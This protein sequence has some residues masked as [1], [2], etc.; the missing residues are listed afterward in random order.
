MSGIINY[1]LSELKCYQLVNS[2][3]FIIIGLF[4]FVRS[5]IFFTRRIL[6]IEFK[7]RRA[8]K[9]LYFLFKFILRTSFL[10]F[11]D[12]CFVMLVADLTNVKTIF[13][14]SI[15]ATLSYTIAKIIFEGNR[16]INLIEFHLGKFEF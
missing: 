1:P 4:A 8:V 15:L 6:N 13:N 12:S 16:R 2:I 5:F 14:N 10:N 7:R 3:V 11:F 9:D